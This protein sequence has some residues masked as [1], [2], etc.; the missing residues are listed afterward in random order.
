[1]S[2]E[3]SEGLIQKCYLLFVGLNWLPLHLFLPLPS[4]VFSTAR[5]F[6][7]Q[8]LLGKR[9]ESMMCHGMG[10]QGFLMGDLEKLSE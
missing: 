2:W 9:A 1:M 7:L 3:G 8:A 4:Y 5:I 6:H 10:S